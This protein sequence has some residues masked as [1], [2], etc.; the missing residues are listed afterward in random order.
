MGLP[1]LR[2]PLGIQVPVHR[3]AP[4]TVWSMFRHQAMQQPKAPAFG[5]PFTGV[6]YQ[7]AYW[8][9][10]AIA[11]YLVDQLQVSPGDRVGLFM[12]NRT[13]YGLAVL[14][15]L[16][17]GA[18]LV[19]LNTRLAP[20]E[21]AGL[22]VNSGARWVIAD[23]ELQSS[24]KEAAASQSWTAGA[25]SDAPGAQW[26]VITIDDLL[27]EAGVDLAAAAPGPKGALPEP[28]LAGDRDVVD[29]WETSVILYTSGTT[30]IPKGA[31][32]THANL[33]NNVLN[34]QAAFKT[35]PGTRT[36]MP[37]PFYHV[38]GLLALFLHTLSVGG[39]IRMLP[40]FS[41][42]AFLDWLETDRIT[43]TCVVPAIYTLA[44]NHPSF[45]DRDLSHWQVAAYGGSP[46]PVEVIRRLLKLAPGVNAI[47]TYGATEVTGSCTFLPPGDALRKPDSVG[48]PTAVHRI[49]I[50][51]E[52]GRDVPAGEVGEIA[53][54][55]ATLTA[56]YWNNPEA[57]EQEFRGGWWF[58]GDLGWMDD[59]GYVYV[60]GRKRETINRGGE[61]IYPLE[62]EETLYNFPSVL[63]AAVV[64]I[65]HPI[66]GQEAA[67]A[68]VPRP[69]S[70]VDIEQLKEF[71]AQRLADYKIPR[72]FVL[73]DSL[74]RNPA[75]KVLKQEVARLLSDSE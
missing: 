25:G 72:R 8:A 33:V 45:T 38:T 35:G 17:C 12:R 64:G 68:V 61:K 23:Q 54:T 40:D 50:V 16:A 73:V 26:Q 39:F 22:L 32:V 63:E 65:P 53:I 20:P 56:G 67:A 13:E 46:M 1:M 10:R 27:Q 36:L 19:P 6:D 42:Q 59:E 47:N 34:F 2:H 5:D 58:S 37:V 24:L 57:T 14:A 9:S 11:A 3:G 31:K 28:P 7:Q 75:G 62:V 4:P 21:L 71:L 52:D 74:P 30:G 51:G 15:C 55:G 69:G 70:S 60:A 66:F 41:T 29:P 48:V 44:V 18:V 43:Y 49:R